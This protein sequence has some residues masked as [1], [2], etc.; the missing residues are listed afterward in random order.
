MNDSTPQPAQRSVSVPGKLLVML[1]FAVILGGSLAIPFFYETQT[2]WYKIGWGKIMLRTGQMAGL[3]AL[4]LL[5]TQVLLALRPRFGERFFG[6]ATLVR[7]HKRNGLL[8]AGAAIAHVFLVVVP[9]G[10]NNWPI[11]MK[12]WPEM[13]GG[14]LL[15]LLIVTV[16]FSQFRA[17]LRFSY[18]GWRRWHRPLGYLALSLAPVHVAFVSESF[19]HPLPRAALLLLFTAVLFA[20]I[21]KYTAH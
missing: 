10:I 20:I 16:L 3:L 18:P 7:W 6:P 21:K 15:I 12:Y 19:Q 2:L 14:A 8:L 4:I 11:G 17:A 13:T 1:T 9:E 5:L